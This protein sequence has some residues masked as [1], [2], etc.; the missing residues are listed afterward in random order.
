MRPHE[1]PGLETLLLLD[2]EI[3]DQRDG[4]WM[5]IEAYPVPPNE[6]VPHGIRYALTLHDPYG[7][8][9]MGYD[10]AH[11]IQPRRQRYSGRRVVYDHK[12]CHPRDKGTAYEFTTAEQ[13]LNDFFDD[14]DEI[15]GK[16]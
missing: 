3:Y 1:H 11:A 10:N 15:L 6:H 16:P 8:R 14:I 7:V 12:H 9:I 5:R 4:Y 13:L 2:G